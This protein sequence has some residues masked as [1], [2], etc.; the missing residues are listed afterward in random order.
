MENKK[1]KTLVINSLIFIFCV[2]II[3]LYNLKPNVETGEIAKLQTYQVTFQ[4]EDGTL[5]S[6]DVE[7]GKQVTPP[8]EP[9]RE[10]YIFRG[11]TANGE[12]FDFNSAITGNLVLEPKWEEQAPDITYY[13]VAFNS[14]GGSSVASQTI[15]EGDYAQHPGYPTKDGFDFVDWT[16]N[17]TSFDFGTPITSNMTITATWREATVE[18]PNKDKEWRVTFN[19]NGGSGSTPA[20][21][22]VKN[23]ETATNPSEKPTRDKYDFVGWSTNKSA[24][25]A[26]ITSTR[27]TKDTVFYA[28]WKSNVKTY[29]VTISLGSG[30]TAT[31]CKTTQ[32]VEEGK[33]PTGC[34]SPKRSG[35]TF[36]GWRSGNNT[37]TNL[38]QFTVTGTMTI[39]A[40]WVAVPTYT[41]TITYNNNGGSGCTSAKQTSTNTSYTFTNL[42][43]PTA[44]NALKVFNS[45]QLNGTNVSKVMLTSTNNTASLTATYKDKSFSVICSIIKN[46][47]GGATSQCRPALASG[48]GSGLYVKVGRTYYKLDGTGSVAINTYNGNVGSLQVCNGGTA[49]ATCVSASGSQAS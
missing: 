12:D 49:S 1:N 21:Q 29:K 39:T 17:G 36:N 40:Q 38:S 6:Y 15:A 20:A 45:W 43:T 37:Y 19:L 24:T 47:S 27:I 8:E 46:D 33:N 41:Y 22:T 14:D 34:T 13:T 48:S 9:T 5:A 42:C 26:N 35:Y 30:A 11:W 23:G 28:V 44:P 10:G 31:N 25:S 4:T 3:G 16:Y 18:D 7:E 2:I 32:T